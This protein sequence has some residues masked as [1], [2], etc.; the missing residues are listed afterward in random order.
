[1]NKKEKNKEDKLISLYPLKPGEAIVELLEI[2]IPKKKI[3]MK[4]K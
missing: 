3:P 2:Q 1:M 4:G